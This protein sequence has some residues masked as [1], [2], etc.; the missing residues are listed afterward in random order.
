MSPS[1][2]AR[3]FHH[4][5]VCLQVSPRQLAQVFLIQQVCLIQQVYRQVSLRHL[6]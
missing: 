6:A 5:Q 4:Q 2:Q 1:Q 3:V